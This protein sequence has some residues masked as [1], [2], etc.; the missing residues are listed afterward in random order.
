MNE[1]KWLKCTKCNK[2]MKPFLAE[3]D[4]CF[5]EQIVDGIKL[6][7]SGGF[8][9][10]RDSLDGNNYAMLC[11][12]CVVELLEFFPESFKEQFNGAHPYSHKPNGKCC[13]YAWDFEDEFVGKS[14]KEIVTADLNEEDIERIIHA[15][16]SGKIPV[17]NLNDIKDIGDK[18]E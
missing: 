4:N 3:H 1:D 10:F 11:H 16:N 5:P 13:R 12:D 17:R 18:H 6:I 2:A 15:A 9:M 7:F 14:Y 8:D